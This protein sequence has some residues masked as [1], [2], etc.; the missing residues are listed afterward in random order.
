MDLYFVLLFCLDF[1]WCVFSVVCVNI[2]EQIFTV[3]YSCVVGPVADPIRFRAKPILLPKL[4]YITHTCEWVDLLKK[5]HFECSIFTVTLHSL[6]LTM[7]LFSFLL[8]VETGQRNNISGVYGWIDLLTKVCN[9]YSNMNIVKFVFGF[10][11]IKCILKDLLLCFLHDRKVAEP[12]N[13][14]FFFFSPNLADIYIETV[15]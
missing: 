6:M 1:V 11:I 2:M 3:K 9:R 14:V 15:Q 12:Y 4:H 7:P 5:V 8:L 10:Y 13:T